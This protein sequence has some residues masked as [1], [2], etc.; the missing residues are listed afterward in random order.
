MKTYKLLLILIFVTTIS[1]ERN[2][3][4]NTAVHINEFAIDDFKDGVLLDVRTPEEYESGHLQ[5]AINI[6]FFNEAFESNL[7]KL[8]K[9]TKVYV[10]CRSGNRSAKTAKL[11]HQLSFK[12]VINLDGGIKAWQ[13]S[14][15]TVIK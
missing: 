3:T 2:A 4:S 9:D 13:A 14:G 1:C 10:Y 5:D 7:L 15:K 8:D 6:D 11:M 12:E